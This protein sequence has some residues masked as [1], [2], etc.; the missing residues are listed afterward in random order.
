MSNVVDHVLDLE[1]AIVNNSSSLNYHVDFRASFPF[2]I[3][4]VTATRT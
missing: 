1:G 2:Q 3:E 4:K